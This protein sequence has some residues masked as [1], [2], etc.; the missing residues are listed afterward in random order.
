MASKPLI[1]D[2]SITEQQ[3]SPHL[4]RRTG[5]RSFSTVVGGGS[6]G[7]DGTIARYTY[8]GDLDAVSVEAWDRGTFPLPANTAL[9][10]SPDVTDTNPW[11]YTA[12][13]DTRVVFMARATVDVT[14]GVVWNLVL[15]LNGTVVSSGS[16]LV[17]WVG[18]V[19]SGWTLSASVNYHASHAAGEV[20]V[21]DISV[22]V[23]A[24]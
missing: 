8:I 4:R 6:T 23:M 16:E 10:S 5:G 14:C 7:A 9:N 13:S 17:T 1:P 12:P 3:L 18:L 2:S 19:P 20:V 21:S 15:K 11:T 24:G 22:E